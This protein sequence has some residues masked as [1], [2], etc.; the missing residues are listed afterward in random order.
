MKAKTTLVARVN[1]K[2]ANFP[3]TAVEIR[4]KTIAFPVRRKDTIRKKIREFGPDQIIGFYARYS[5]GGRRKVKPLGKDPISAFTEYQRIEKDFERVRQGLEPLNPTPVA[6]KKGSRNVV[7]LA[8]EFKEELKTLGRKPRSI[9]SYS[10]SIDQFLHSYKKQSIDEVDR[11]DILNFIVWMQVNLVKRNGG[12][13]N[14]TYRNRLRDVGIFLK[15][16]GVQMPLP[17]REWPKEV[18]KK[19]EKY[20]IAVINDMLKAAKTEDEKDLIHFLLKTGFRDDEVAHVQYSD[21][22]SRNGTINISYKK[23]FN[24]T[25][26]DNEPRKEAITLEDRFVKRM[27]LRRARYNASSSGLIF[28]SKSGTPNNHLIRVI[29]RVAKR[30]GI[31]VRIGLHKFRKTFGTMVAQKYGLERARL[32]LGHDDIATTQAYLAA[33][34]QTSVESRKAINEMFEAVGD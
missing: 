29:Q 33:D 17:T 32:W 18:E 25:P 15:H 3:F 31:D 10:G 6:A 20:S 11:K 26:K 24:W 13:P 9:E 19:K 2:E 23:E 14:N 1:D 21:I 4:K 28:P 5:E 7:L 22:D 16:F 27:R 12:H 34:E 8:R 30:A